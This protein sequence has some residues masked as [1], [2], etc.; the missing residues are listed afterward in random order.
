MQEVFR[1]IRQLAGASGPVL[2]VGESG[3]GKELVARAIHE[4]SERR[5]GRFLAVNCAGIPKDLLESEFFGHESGA[6]TGASRLRKGIFEEAQGGTLLLD[7][8]SEMPLDLQAK[9]LRVL[10]DGK[11]RPVGSN[12]EKEVDVR[13]LAASNRDIER[14]V[15]E[16]GFREDLFYRL[17]TFQLKLPPLRRRGGDIDLLTGCFLRKYSEVTGKRIEGLSPRAMELLHMYPFPGNVR[18]LQNAI[19][20]AVFFCGGREIKPEHL[21]VRLRKHSQSSQG[22]KASEILE[23][24]VKDGDGLPSLETV[25]LAYI[26]YALDSLGGNKR[27]AAEKLGIARRTLYRKI[28]RSP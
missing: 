24:L 15:E 2:I 14:Q 5:H 3:T 17:E 10:Q 6:F 25:E 22:V 27:L 16:G 19:E 11:L 21:P 4:E 1:Q 23:S 20:R 12:L 13:V 28:D 26:R 8:I 7:E 9:L 18:E